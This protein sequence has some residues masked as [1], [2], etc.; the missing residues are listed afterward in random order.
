MENQRQP[1]VAVFL[2][3][4]HSV[5]ASAQARCDLDVDYMLGQLRTAVADGDHAKAMR[6]WLLLPPLYPVLLDVPPEQRRRAGDE[7]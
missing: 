6:Y 7:E 3:R 2:S 1:E 4:L 5:Q